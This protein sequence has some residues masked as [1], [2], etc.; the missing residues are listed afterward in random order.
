TEGEEITPGTNVSLVFSVLNF[1]VASAGN[2]DGHVHYTVNGGGVTMVYT[3]DPI[4][5]GVLPAGAYTVDMEL[6]DDSHAPLSPAVTATVNF[7]VEA[8]TQV[9]D[10]AALR[11]DFIANG[12]GAY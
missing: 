1:D 6:V 11:A 4:D 8:A 12:P 2:G 10:L 7:T 9:A 5:L 3:T